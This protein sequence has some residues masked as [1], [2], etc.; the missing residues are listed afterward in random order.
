MA[1]NLDRLILGLLLPDRAWRS[2]TFVRPERAARSLA[3]SL[4]PRIRPVAAREGRRSFSE[5]RELERPMVVDHGSLFLRIPRSRLS[6]QA[7]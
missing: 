2:P 3:L 6:S 1:P 7:S 4:L 5:F